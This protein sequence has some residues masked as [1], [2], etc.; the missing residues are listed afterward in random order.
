MDINIMMIG[1]RRCGKT[2]VLASMQNSFDKVFGKSNLTIEADMDSMLTLSEKMDEIQGLY[3]LKNTTPRFT[4]DDNPTE[5]ITEYHLSISLKSKPKG[6][7][8]YNFI[9]FPGEWIQSKEHVTEVERLVKT[10]EV[11]VVAIDTPHLMEEAP[12]NE[13]ESVGIYNEKQNRCK[14]VCEFLK[15]VPLEGNPKM[16][17]FVPL[18]SEKYQIENKMELVNKRVKTAYASFFDYIDNDH[19]RKKC[20]VVISPIFTLGTVQFTRF[21]RE[22]AEIILHE[23]Y[24]TPK[25]PLYSFTDKATNVPEP[26]YCEQPLLYVLYYLLKAAQKNREDKTDGFWRGVFGKLSEKFFKMPSSEDFMRE[27]NTIQKEIKINGDGY[28][29]ISDPL[30]LKGNVI[31]LS[32]LTCILGNVPRFSPSKMAKNRENT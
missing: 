25:Y 11:F 26:Q 32:D 31:N 20:T 21:K 10:S 4:P 8:D 3:A 7:I 9:D 15:K 23:K 24:L 1:G 2:S 28:E 22:G 13:P 17:I 27:M 16:V 19:N 29:I 5:Q 18:K 6:K 14:M 30:G 12:D